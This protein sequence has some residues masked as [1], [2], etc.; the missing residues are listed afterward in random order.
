MQGRPAVGEQ[1]R[2]VMA[3]NWEPPLLH[4]VPSHWEPVM[5][6]E[7]WEES[8]EVWE[9]REAREVWEEADPP[10]HWMQGSWE[11]VRQVNPWA[12]QKAAPPFWHSDPSHCPP[13][14]IEEFWEETLEWTE[15]RETLEVREAEELGEIFDT[16]E[17][18]TSWD[19]LLD[20]DD[21]LPVDADDDCALQLCWQA[22]RV[23]PLGIPCASAHA[24]S[25][26]TWRQV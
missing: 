1:T 26:A 4:S 15:E 6:E 2:P 9:E 18:A 17:D 19:T 10:T 25:F 22:C 13:I 23:E 21:M 12:A 14:V 20:C 7:V 11:V 8:W 24:W 16:W 3:Q 5:V